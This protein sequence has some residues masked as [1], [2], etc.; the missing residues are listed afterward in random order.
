MIKSVEKRV[1]KFCET[2]LQG[3]IDKMFCSTPCRNA[4]HN[5]ERHFRERHIRTINRILKRNWKI[6]TRLNKT[7]KTK[8]KRTRLLA[9]EF[10]FEYHTSV[11]ITKAGNTYY[12]CYDQGYLE[13]PGEE[14]LLVLS[15]QPKDSQANR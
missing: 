15:F 12:Y 9:M 2:A 14:V 10:D 1:C 3:R 11:L 6:L 5:Q 8:V 13:L 7:D 4:W